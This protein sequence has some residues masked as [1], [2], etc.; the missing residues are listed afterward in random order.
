MKL[1]TIPKAGAKWRAW[2]DPNVLPDGTITNEIIVQLINSISADEWVQKYS[3]YGTKLVESLSPTGSYWLITFNTESVDP[4]ILLE[5]MRNDSQVIG[6]E[7]NME[8]DV[9]YR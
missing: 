9:R 8:V 1:P 4:D 3:R 7:F 2:I 6:A 5:N